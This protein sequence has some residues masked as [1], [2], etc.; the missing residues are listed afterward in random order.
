MHDFQIE[1]VSYK[2]KFLKVNL[3]I[4]KKNKKIMK[5]KIFLKICIGFIDE[6]GLLFAYQGR[7]Q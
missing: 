5:H 7:T 2:I 6:N 4:D 3:F 1:I